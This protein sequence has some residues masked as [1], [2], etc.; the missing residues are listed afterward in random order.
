[1][2][3]L[4]VALLDLALPQECAGCEAGGTRWCPPCARALAQAAAEPLGRCAPQPCPAGFPRTA[5][6]AAYDGVVRSALLAHKERGR[7]ALVR[8]LAAALAGAVATLDLAPGPLVLVPAP[9]RR[10]T[11]RARGQDHARRLARRTAHLL[12]QTGV[13]VTAAGLLLPARELADQSGLDVASRAANLAGALRARRRLDGVRVVL[14]DD[15]VTSGATLVEAA[16]ALTAAGALVEGA[17]V[18]AA[19]QRT[20]RSQDHPIGFS[21]CAFAVSGSTVEP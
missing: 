14:V 6:A 19:T 9:S 7:L 10:A 4:W 18:V 17:V 13:D 8:P 15:V 20:Q 5:A 2:T 11:V 16:R 12:R 3:G 21:P 1:M